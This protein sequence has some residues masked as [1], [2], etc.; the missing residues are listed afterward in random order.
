MK[1]RLR[2][3]AF[4]RAIKVLTDN[5]VDTS[6][7]CDVYYARLGL[8]VPPVFRPP[9]KNPP[10]PLPLIQQLPKADLDCRLI[11]S[12]PATVLFKFF[13]DLPEDQR[14]SIAAGAQINTI[15]EFK[16]FLSKAEN[17]SLPSEVKNFVIALLQTEANVREA[18]HAL[19]FDAFVDKVVYL[20]L[21]VCP[22]YHTRQGLTMEETLDRILD[23]IAKF[24]TKHSMRV[25]LV[26]NANIEKQSP[27]DVHKLAQLAVA[28][29]TRG[30]LGFATT[31]AEIGVAQ[32]RY[33]EAT[34]DNL[35]ENF[36][37]VTL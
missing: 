8:T 33:F 29:Q 4:L 22:L 32:M 16:A 3:E 17:G 5:G 12:V 1:T 26:V 19:L 28:Y 27:L 18:V 15:D 2:I 30:V 37:P 7:I 35:S 31:S 20:E 25:G 14:K 21:T 23:E 24:R 10:L 9:V 11:G 6:G 13:I 34:F 36:M